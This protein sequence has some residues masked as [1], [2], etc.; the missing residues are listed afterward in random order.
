MSKKSA[1]WRNCSLSTSPLTATTSSH[2]FEQ[3]VEHIFFFHPLHV[4]TP[5]LI[6]SQFVK[7]RTKGKT[8]KSERKWEVICISWSSIVC[9]VIYLSQVI[10]LSPMYVFL[11]CLLDMWNKSL[12]LVS[13]RLVE[14]PYEILLLC[15][16]TI[17]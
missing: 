6:F 14:T 1:T 4:I 9:H 7:S 10:I 13:G 3:L 16:Y 15:V 8:K 11:S 17:Y 2:T 5:F 12:I